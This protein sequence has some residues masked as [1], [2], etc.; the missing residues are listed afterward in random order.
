MILKFIEQTAPSITCRANVQQP[1]LTG[2]AVLD[3]I[4]PIGR[5]QRELIIGDRSTGKSYLAR[6]ICLNQ[7]RNNR[8]LTPDSF[9]RDR[10]FCIYACI[11]LRSTEVRRLFYF[12]QKNGIA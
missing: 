12:I 7:K 6:A 10:I 1:L 5:G 4:V 9:G 8:F 2:F 11:G 3:T